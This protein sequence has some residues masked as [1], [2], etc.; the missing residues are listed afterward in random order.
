MS[1]WAEE[2]GVEFDNNIRRWLGVVNV[3]GGGVSL[4]YTEL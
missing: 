3:G 4:V 2:V 1:S